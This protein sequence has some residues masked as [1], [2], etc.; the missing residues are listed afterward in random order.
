MQ[1][2][3]DTPTSRSVVLD[4]WATFGTGDPERIGAV[5]APDAEWLAPAGNAA[6]RI[7]GDHHLVGRERIVAFL[8]SEFATVFG[9]RVSAEVERVVAEGDTVVL[10]VRL[11]S[12]LPGGRAYDNHY[13]FLF[14]VRDGVVHRV[15]EHLDTHRGLLAFGLLDGV[16]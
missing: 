9:T 1:I 6:A 3:T 14:T 2:T 12:V 5:F 10:Q 15:R 8:G 11:Q 4:A 16:D 7:V 13:C